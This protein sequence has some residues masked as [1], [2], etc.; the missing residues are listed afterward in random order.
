MLAE[1]W[2]AAAREINTL[3]G[4]SAQQVE[5]GASVSANA[6]RSFEG[7]QSS[8]TRTGASISA[9]AAA[10]EEQRRMAGEV[11]ELIQTLTSQVTA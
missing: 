9:I 2:S 3:I 10:A 7:I 8:V 1:R 4:E 6:A 11:S 5:R